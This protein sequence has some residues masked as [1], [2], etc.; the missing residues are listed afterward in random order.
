[1]KVIKI[2]NFGRETVNDVL[3]ADNL[4]PHMAK[5]LALRLNAETNLYGPDY[6]TAVEDGY[7]LYEFKP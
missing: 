1:M 3:I 4:S 5:K 6:Y 7:Q 2:D